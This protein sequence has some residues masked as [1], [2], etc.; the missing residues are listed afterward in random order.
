[1]GPVLSLVIADPQQLLAEGL[2][3][4]L[5]AE[6]DFAVLGVAHDGPGALKLTAE[7]QPAV[8]LLGAPL[9]GSALTATPTAVKAVSPA[10]K[11]LLLAGQAPWDQVAAVTAAGA[12]GLLPRDSSSRQVANAVRAVVDGTPAIVMA[13]KPARPSHD[14]RVD[15]RV[16]TLSNRERELLGLLASGWSNRRIAEECFLS[17]HTVR[18]HVQSI[19]VKLGVHSKLEAVAFA[20]QHSLVPIGDRD[21]WDRHSA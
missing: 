17:L 16:G 21:V 11:L 13:T 8:L 19:L 15:L 14:P 7:H 6:D 5:D 4:L 2:A 1:M 20:Y 9:P 3:I 10:T 18:T 12:D